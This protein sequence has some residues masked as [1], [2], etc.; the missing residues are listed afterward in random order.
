MS[1]STIH[2]TNQ[3]I[4]TNQATRPKPKPQKN[5]SSGIAPNQPPNRPT[6][7]S[8]TARHSSWERLDLRPALH[9]NRGRERGVI[10]ISFEEW[11]AVR[12]RTLL[13]RQMLSWTALA[14]LAVVVGG[15]TPS[16]P[17]VTLGAGGPF[18]DSGAQLTSLTVDPLRSH[19]LYLGTR[20]GLFTSTD[21]AGH[22][23]IATHS[24]FADHGVRAI[25]PSS[26]AGGPLWLVA[27]DG[28]IWSSADGGG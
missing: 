4:L 17:D 3:A 24:V 20:R 27:G 23:P 12:I 14:L 13:A 26:L 19:R 8:P 11:A 9:Y 1:I 6:T 15:C 25:A 16:V 5:P 28:T 10:L 18:A 21:G 2:K 22:W 7:N